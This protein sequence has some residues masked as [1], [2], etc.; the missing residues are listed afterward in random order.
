M[1]IANCT[2]TGTVTEQKHST[3]KPRLDPTEQPKQRL[4][5][6]QSGAQLCLGC[7]AV[8]MPLHCPASACPAPYESP[9]ASAGVLLRDT[10]LHGPE[11]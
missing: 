5:P 8:L 6:Q 1:S 2:S 7:A 4:E 11:S 9:W 3:E 10:A